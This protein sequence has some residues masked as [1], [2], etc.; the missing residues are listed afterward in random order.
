M[1]F[2]LARVGTMRQWP[3]PVVAVLMAAVHLVRVCVRI[4]VMVRIW[5]KGKD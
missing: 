5:A 2:G 4:G 3:P 1:V